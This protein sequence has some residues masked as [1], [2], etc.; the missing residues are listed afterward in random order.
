MVLSQ[1][2]EY[3]FSQFVLLL[4]QCLQKLSIKKYIVFKCVCDDSL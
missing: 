4:N 1:S 2:Y 3:Y